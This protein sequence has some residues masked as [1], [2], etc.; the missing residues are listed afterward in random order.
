M[1]TPE[2]SG[3]SQ[4]IFKFFNNKSNEEILKGNALWCVWNEFICHEGQ[5]CIGIQVIHRYFKLMYVIPVTYHFKYG[6]YTG[7]TIH[8]N[9]NKCRYMGR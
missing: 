7:L 9:L 6:E 4:L 2:L 8:L 1:N 5:E 3:D